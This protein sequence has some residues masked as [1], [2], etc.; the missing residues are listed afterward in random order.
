MK[1]I[2][3]D[4]GKGGFNFGITFD[5][6][7]E[8][9]I[10]LNLALKCREELLRHGVEVE[11]TR[12]DDRYLGYSERIVKGNK[13]RSDAF[14]SIHCN[15]G[16]GSLAE[17]IYSADFRRGFSLANAVGKEIKV[18]GQSAVKIYNR[19]GHGFLDFNTVIREA[20]MDSIIVKCA[21]LDN[22]YDRNLIN[23]DEKQNNFGIAIA[24][25][26][27]SYLNI[28]YMEK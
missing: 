8:K 20:L 1:R 16:G 2:T 27:L 13:N 22:E 10:N 11:M 25:G 5:N 9:E 28:D 15:G 24:K 17:L 7:V 12:E 26:I 14:V 18:Y 4:P 19:L 23:T 6:L 21:F 3:L